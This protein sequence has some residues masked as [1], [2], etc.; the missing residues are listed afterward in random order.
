MKT[1][2][3]HKLLY[4]VTLIVITNIC[5]YP[6]VN[7]DF[8]YYWDDQWVVMNTYTTE[9]LTLHNLI[10]TFTDFYHG[11]YAPLNE[12][13]YIIIYSCW[14]YNPLPFHIANIIWHSINILLSFLF[15]YK[16]LKKLLPSNNYFLIAF[17][18]VLLWGIHPL[19]V[20]S[21]AWISASK[22]LIYTC[23]YLIASLIYLEY[24]EKKKIIYYLLSFIF[25]SFS[26]LGK[27]QAVVFPLFLLL[28]DWINNR[29]LKTKE[30]WLEKTPFFI[31]ALFFGLITILSQGNGGNAPI[32]PIGQR[33]V[34]GCYTLFEYIIKCIIPIKLLYIYPFPIQ[35]GEILPLRFYLY[36]V[37][38]LI[39]GYCIFIL[40][41]RKILIFSFLFFLI[42]I[43]VALH[44]IPISRFA[45]VAD[46]YVYLSCLSITFLFAFYGIKIWNKTKF[47]TLYLIICAIYFLYLAT[48]TNYYS[49]QWKST[50]SLKKEMREL[51]K[52]REDYYLYKKISKESD[53]KSMFN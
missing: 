23:F 10:H 35:V 28:L 47:R 19:T 36:P 48:Y 22:V 52:H 46:R 4:C 25:F 1:N 32:Y 27:E 15:F 26:F 39:L 18:T 51:L 20:E 50:T 40:G 53:Y 31:C 7:S 8:L 42:H 12:L 30:I 38:L 29:N 16:L 44:I 37:I 6:I 34:L 3:K 9:G 14:G 17:F 45:I 2:K 41:K 49:R 5:Y 11:Q 21:V 13:N 33:L 24:L 43:V